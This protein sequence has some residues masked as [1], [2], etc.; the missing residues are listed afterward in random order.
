MKRIFLFTLRSRLALWLA[1][2]VLVIFICACGFVF[3]GFR[4]AAID[5]DT[6]ARMEYQTKQEIIQQNVA[7]YLA[8][9]PNLDEVTVDKITQLLEVQEECLQG[10]ITA[11]FS[12][13]W[14]QELS[15]AVQQGE[16]E[17]SLAELGA[18]PYDPALS[19]R[20]AF[21]QY[22]LSHSIPPKTPANKVDG[23]SALCQYIR[24][25]GFFVG[26]LF[27][28][29]LSLLTFLMERETGELRFLFQLPVT[30]RNLLSGKCLGVFVLSSVSIL[31]IPLALFMVCS[32]LFG[33]GD[34][35]YP[36]E[37]LDGSFLP[38]GRFLWESLIS[39][40]VAVAFFTALGVLLSILLKSTSLGV[41]AVISVVGISVFL[42]QL[43]LPFLD[44]FPLRS[45]NVYSM[46]TE[47]TF[48]LW[49]IIVVQLI[50]I[51]GIMAGGIIIW[52]KRDLI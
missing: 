46:I 11:R 50:S 17:L 13:D 41:L 31:I 7:T 48:P 28:M 2:T 16:G 26:A 35:R 9:N 10:M 30:R 15:L 4:Q 25:I 23:I 37:C 45:A 8:E 33:V 12:G 42:Q 43:S 29:M 52:K 3:L 5:Y 49:L 14:H 6:L 44:W 24:W 32:A 27:P 47:S 20:L 18:F 21:N 19:Q 40:V 39:S 22:L 34:P 36:L 51:V 38:T 1:S